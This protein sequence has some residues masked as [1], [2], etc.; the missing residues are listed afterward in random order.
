MKLEENT[1]HKN[2]NVVKDKHSS[3]YQKQYEDDFVS[4]WDDLIDWDGRTK[5]EGDFFIKAL[6]ERNAKKVLD[7]ATGTGYHSVRLLNNGFEVHSVDGKDNMLERAFFNARKKGLILRTIHTDWRDLTHDIHE[8]YDAVICLGNSFTHLFEEKDRRK[9]LAEF[10]SI[11]GPQGILILDQRNYDTIL[12]RG[13]SN[14]HEYYYVG[15][16]VKAE[17]ESISDD[18][19]RFRYEFDDNAVHH[20]NMFPLRKEYTQSLIK[21]AGFPTVKTYGD[22]Q[23]TY[24]QEEPDFFIHVAEK[25]Y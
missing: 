4:K 16:S 3:F 22:F 19:V 15:D 1:S 8:T 21:E 13:Y 9:V 24:K 7:A 17:P 5:G 2:D 18:L 10:Y 6:K 23:E 14:K 11:L 25:N 12:D 20:L